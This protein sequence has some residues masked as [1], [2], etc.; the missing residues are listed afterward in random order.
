MTKGFLTQFLKVKISNGKKI[1]VKINDV[2]D[3]YYK[4]G[5]IDNEAN[6]LFTDKLKKKHTF[7]KLSITYIRRELGVNLVE[8]DVTNGLVMKRDFSGTK[9]TDT[10]T[11]DKM[12]QKSISLRVLGE[13]EAWKKVEKIIIIGIAIGVIYIVYILSTQETV[14]CPAII[15][16]VSNITNI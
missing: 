12:L 16:T 10:T 1:L 9:G 5:V 6:L 15:Q 13:D 4:S 7:T 11:Y 2:A 14:S 8:V 3:T